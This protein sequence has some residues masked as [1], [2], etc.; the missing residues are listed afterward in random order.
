MRKAKRIKLHYSSMD[1]KGKK[2][3]LEH[4]KSRQNKAEEQVQ[5]HTE[6]KS[7]GKE[8]KKRRRIKEG[9]VIARIFPHMLRDHGQV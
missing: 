6:V 7:Q 1:R 9:K 4:A 5:T 8:G 2:N 3:K